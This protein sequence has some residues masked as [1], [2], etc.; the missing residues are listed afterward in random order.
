[1]AVAWR[2]SHAVKGVGG[3]RHAQRAQATLELLFL[4][5]A[6]V[7]FVT[8]FI[9]LTRGIGIE[10]R[11][12]AE[13]QSARYLAQANCFLLEYFALNGRNT[14]LDFKPTGLVAGSSGEVVVSYGN[15]SARVSCIAR[16]RSQNG[17]VVEQV[18]F[19][20]V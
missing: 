5:T 13:K 14:E 9:A 11:E 1:M 12:L 7:A 2:K 15:A 3:A 10:A 16:A 18:G 4:L 17:L 8:A 19:E 6:Y 20:P